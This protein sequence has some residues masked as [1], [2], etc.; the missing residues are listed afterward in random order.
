MSI[1]KV[2]LKNSRP[3]KGRL[4]PVVYI[5]ASNQKSANILATKKT[6]IN[7]NSLTVKRL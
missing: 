2:T 6:L 4:E 3:V 5:D 1:Y 7:I